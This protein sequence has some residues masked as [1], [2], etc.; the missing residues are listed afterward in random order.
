M[1]TLSAS[2]LRRM[3]QSTSLRATGSLIDFCSS[4]ACADLPLRAAAIASL[5]AATSTD[6]VDDVGATAN[7]GEEPF[8]RDAVSLLFAFGLAAL[9]LSAL[10]LAAL[11]LAALSLAA[12]SFA[13]LSFAAASFDLALSFDAP[14]S[15]AAPF[16]CPFS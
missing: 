10:S 12:F 7:A 16:S 2:S 6:G 11:S 9:A 1:S 3:A 15:D 14:L 8:G 4:M 13:A 5:T